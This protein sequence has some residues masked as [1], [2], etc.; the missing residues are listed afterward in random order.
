MLAD[1]ALRDT[2]MKVLKE[3][4]G[5]M[6]AER[7]VTLLLRESF[8]YTKWRGNFVKKFEGMSVEEVSKLAM[9]GYV[10]DREK[11]K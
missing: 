6:E 3:N 4:L 11:L 9:Q 5:L 10:P 7:F 8:D 1:T 2:G